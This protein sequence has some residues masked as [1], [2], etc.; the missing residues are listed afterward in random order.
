MMQTGHM[1]ACQHSTRPNLKPVNAATSA[2][3]KMDSHACVAKVSRLAGRSKISDMERTVVPLLMPSEHDLPF[4]LCLDICY[5]STTSSTTPGPSS[6]SLLPTHMKS[7]FLDILYVLSGEGE[8]VGV[9]GTRSRVTAR[10]SVIA[11]AQSTRIDHGGSKGGLVA[12]LRFSIPLELV[13]QPSK[14]LAIGSSTE[15]M[16]AGMMSGLTVD[17]SEGGSMNVDPLIKRRMM[18]DVETIAVPF[19][20]QRQMETND[21]ADDLLTEDESRHIMSNIQTKAAAAMDHLDS[22]PTL[23]STS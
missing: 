23:S 21:G 22:S 3:M 17:D 13:P 20:I 1:R 6:E 18:R 5:A 9:D 11:W 15:A 2:S 14:P 12:S 8:L 10:D 7:S 19:S 16:D 4:A